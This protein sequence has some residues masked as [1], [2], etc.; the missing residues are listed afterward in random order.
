MKKTLACFLSFFLILSTPSVV[1]Q[2]PLGAPGIPALAPVFEKIGVVAAAHGTVEL[3]TPGQVGR[4]A[5]SGQAVFMGDEITTD[6][7]GH[8]QILFLDQTVFHQDIQCVVN[9]LARVNYPAVFYQ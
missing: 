4:I 6:E 9:I 8:L 5:Q 3:T 7:K 1:A 2:M